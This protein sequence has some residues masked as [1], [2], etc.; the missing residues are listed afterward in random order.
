MLKK[1]IAILKHNF[2]NY[3]YKEFESIKFEPIKEVFTHK[4]FS[5]TV[6]IIITVFQSYYFFV[7][8][9]KISTIPVRSFPFYFVYFIAC[10]LT[11]FFVDLISCLIFLFRLDIL[12]V[13]FKMCKV[14]SIPLLFIFRIIN[15]TLIVIF[16]F[17]ISNKDKTIFNKIDYKLKI[18]LDYCVNF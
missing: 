11:L 3:V 13:L 8:F 15:L 14:I 17:F 4:S 9:S 7:W 10:V 18:L 1:L 6:F 5:I 12:K 16:S 2:R